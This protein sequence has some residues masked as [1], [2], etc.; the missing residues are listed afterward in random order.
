MKTIIRYQCQFCLAKIANAEFKEDCQQCEQVHE[1]NLKIVEQ[2]YDTAY[3]FPYCIGIQDPITGNTIYYG[4][5]SK[6]AIKNI[7]KT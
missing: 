6:E 2:K 5:S 1:Q 3:R 4:K 7:S